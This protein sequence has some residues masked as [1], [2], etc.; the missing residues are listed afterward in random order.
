MC[1]YVCY[2]QS[3]CFYP[4]YESRTPLRFINK[5]KTHKQLFGRTLTLILIVSPTISTLKPGGCR[6]R[7]KTEPAI[8]LNPPERRAIDKR[9]Q[10]P[11]AGGSV[12]LSPAFLTSSPTL[13]R[14]L[15]NPLT[16]STIIHACVHYF[17]QTIFIFFIFW[18]LCLQHPHYECDKCYF[19][20]K[21]KQPI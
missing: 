10:H 19:D 18:R 21:V 20:T 11:L 12:F 6:L 15:A 16:Y 7:R 17:D 5:Q 1:C 13:L 3:P 8:C 2:M 4:Y 9:G 14:Q